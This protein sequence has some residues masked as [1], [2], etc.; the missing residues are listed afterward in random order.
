MPLLAQPV[1]LVSSGSRVVVEPAEPAPGAPRPAGEW[2]ARLP[3]AVL[4]WSVVCV[5]LGLTLFVRNRQAPG[6][7]QFFDPVLPALA[8]AFPLAGALLASRRRRY[9]LEW[10]LLAGGV[11]A[12]GFL[13]EQYA[14]YVIH[15]EPGRL[16]GGTWAAWVSTW[17]WAPA[18]LAALTLLPLLFP[19]GHPPSPRWR[20]V[21]WVVVAGIAATTLAAALS[22]EHLASPAPGN[23]LAVA[24]LA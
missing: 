8:L 15:A 5:A 1:R 9:P 7:E 14:V 13:C 17:A 23:P 3:H 20:P 21:V 12:A 11:S 6:T 16:G 2:L 24:G 19:D 18:Y 10:V 22:S 4:A